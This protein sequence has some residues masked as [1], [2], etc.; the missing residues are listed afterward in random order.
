MDQTGAPLPPPTLGPPAAP[1]PMPPAGA[2]APP[3]AAPPPGRRANTGMVVAAII[4]VLALVGIGLVVFTGDDSSTTSPS[5][6]TTAAEAS[7]SDLGPG[8]VWLEPLG[9]PTPDPFTDGVLLG[10]E[11]RPTVTL[12]DIGLPTTTAPT[13]VDGAQV[14]GSTPGLYGGTRNNRS[15]DKEAMIAFLE[16]NPAKAEAWAGVQGIAVADIRTFIEGLTPVIL[17]R[18]TRVTNHGFENGAAYAHPSVLAAGS[19]VLVDEFGVPRAKCSCG[20]PL[21]P[22]QPLP[23]PPIYVGDDWPEFDPPTVVIVI[24]TVPVDGGFVLVDVDTGDTIVRPVGGNDETPDLATGDI[25]V[26]LT[27]SDAADIDLKVI[28]PSGDY[29]DYNYP[30]SASGGQL[31]VDAN[32]ACGS[33]MTPAVENIVWPDTAPPGVYAIEV[34]LYDECGTPSGAHD[35]TVTAFVGGIRVPLSSDPST[36]NP[37]DGAYWVSP[38]LPT[39]TLYFVRS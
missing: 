35:F 17:T 5:G 39:Q 21:L 25:R 22:P 36:M 12:P 18:D 15:C 6:S 4:A 13:E 23:E 14:S 28:D 8:E 2:G 37:Y 27:W 10:A 19:A 24:A 3:P 38:E 11:L 31:D 1:P 20:N 29:V 7:P 30:S 9:A 33:V 32:Q 34:N 16:S 26:T